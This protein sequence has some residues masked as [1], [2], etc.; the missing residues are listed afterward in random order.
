[1]QAVGV[2]SQGVHTRK[3]IGKWVKVVL[4]FLLFLFF[5]AP[6]LLVVMNSAKT[7]V[8]ISLSPVALPGN[9][10]QM[11]TN[12]VNTLTNPNFSYWGA[13]RDSAIITFFS[14]AVIVLCSA[15][16]AWVLVWNK[17]WWSTMIFIVLDASP[18][19]AECGLDSLDLL[20]EGAYIPRELL[21][22]IV[23]VT[24]NSHGVSAITV[25]LCLDY[26][27]HES[28]NSVNHVECFI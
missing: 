25:H 19:K 13:F 14:L 6:F 17:T 24:T 9:W 23:I 20:F 7:A 15:M 8:E 27:D 2:Q 3:V 26:H 1:M 11:G 16:C 12:I 10:G 21:K 22:S 4:A 18:V 5:M 28:R